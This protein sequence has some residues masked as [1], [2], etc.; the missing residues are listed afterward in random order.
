MGI[1]I[2]K[3]IGYGLTDV[4]GDKDTWPIA[5]PRIN[6][7]SLAFDYEM[8]LK[9]YATWLEERYP[10]LDQSKEG[11]ADEFRERPLMDQFWLR[12]RQRESP[13]DVRARTRDI[14]DCVIYSPEYGLPNVLLIQPVAMYDWSRYA[15]AIDYPWEWLSHPDSDDH[16]EHLPGPIYPFVTWMD[17]DT[18]QRVNDD[19]MWVLRNHSRPRWIMRGSLPVLIEPEERYRYFPREGLRDDET[20]GEIAKNLGFDGLE[21][22]REHVVPQVPGE[23]R[24]LCEFA[25]MFTDDAT[26]RSLRPL[27]YTYWG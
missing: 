18:G 23:V 12:D 25:E 4:Q 7:K 15:D 3:A 10:E 13:R 21:W 20:L 6:D 14:S 22:L 9:A 24:D 16:V 2:H 8:D 5:D 11:W 26:W 27:I 1:R 17:K 19:H